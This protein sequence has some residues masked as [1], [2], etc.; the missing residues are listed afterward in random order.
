MSDLLEIYQ[1]LDNRL[2]Q[3]EKDHRDSRD[4]LIEIRTTLKHLDNKIG[5]QNVSI[6]KRE[7]EIKEIERDISGLCNDIIKIKTEKDTSIRNTRWIVVA[8]GV[9][10]AALEIYVI[11]SK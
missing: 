9:M 8:I 7:L 6:G 5:I 4:L 10:L 3:V 2:N 11:F 1:K